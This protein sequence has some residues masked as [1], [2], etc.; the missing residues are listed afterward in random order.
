LSV[1]PRFLNFN[2]NPAPSTTVIT[3]FSTS[4][5]TTYSL[6]NVTFYVTKTVDLVNGSGNVI[7][8]PLGW[9]VCVPPAP[10]G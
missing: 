2:L 3:A 5:M 1:Q 10:P 4:T 6:V 7:C 8:I 9:I